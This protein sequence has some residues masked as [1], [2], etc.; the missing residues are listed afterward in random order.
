MTRINLLRGNT[1]PTILSIARE[2]PLGKGRKKESRSQTEGSVEKKFFYPPDAMGMGQGESRQPSLKELHQTGYGGGDWDTQ[3]EEE[4]K[5]FPGGTSLGFITRKKRRVLRASVSFGA[6]QAK[7]HTKNEK[8][9]CSKEAEGRLNLD[10]DTE[11]VNPQ[12]ETKEKKSPMKGTHEG[13]SKRGRLSWVSVEAVRRKLEG[14][15][16]QPLNCSEVPPKNTKGINLT[17]KRGF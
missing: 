6:K 4:G 10:K 14:Q 16:P 13:K 2:R 8:G 15:A 11:R 17:K 12:K 5:L 9:T 1:R 7:G 3:K